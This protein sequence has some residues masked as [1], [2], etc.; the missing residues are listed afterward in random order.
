MCLGTEVLEA[1]FCRTLIRAIR[2]LPP[3]I[4][5]T[6]EDVVATRTKTAVVI[7]AVAA[8]KEVGSPAVGRAASRSWDVQRCS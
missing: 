1:G 4:G 8:V 7:Q 3:T 2:R 5:A 6:T